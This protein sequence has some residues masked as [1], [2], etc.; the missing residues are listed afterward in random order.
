M[1]DGKREMKDESGELKSRR[2]RAG[3]SQKQEGK[4]RRKGDL[5]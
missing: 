4:Q 3:R 5:V 2:Q 1:E